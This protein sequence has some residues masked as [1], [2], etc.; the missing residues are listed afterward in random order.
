MTERLES[1]YEHIEQSNKQYLTHKGSY[2]VNIESFIHLWQKAMEE[3]HK[4]EEFGNTSYCQEN[5]EDGE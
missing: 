1:L 2:K 3:Q 4:V 5:T